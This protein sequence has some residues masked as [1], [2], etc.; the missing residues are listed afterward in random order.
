LLG[1]GQN[2]QSQWWKDTVWT[3][4]TDQMFGFYMLK[5][6]KND[7]IIVGHGYGVEL[8]D[9][10]SIFF[11]AK[12][13]EEIKR[14]KGTNEVFFINNDRNFVRLR[15]NKSKFEIFDT[16]TFFVIDSLESDAT[17]IV[18]YPPICISKD[19]RYIAA[20]VSDGFR[21]W[22]IQSKRIFKTKIY[23][24]E[25]DRVTCRMTELIFTCDNYLIGH[26]NR[27][28]QDPEH[29]GDS[30]YYKKYVYYIV[31]DLNN[32][33]SIDSFNH[34]LG[35]YISPNCKYYATVTG[36][37][38]YGADVYD[39][40]T[41]DLLWKIP[42]NSLTLTGLEFSP[43]DKYLVTSSSNSDYGLKIWKLETGKMWFEY[44]SGATY[45]NIDVSHNGK[46]I[47]FSIGRT[48]G[49]FKTHFDDVSVN[50]PFEPDR[51]LYPNPTNDYINIIVQNI[52]TIQEIGIYN[53]FGER[54]MTVETQNFVSLQK[55]DVSSLPPGVYF[56]K[57][58]NAKPMKFMVVR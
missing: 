41:K 15:E 17:K 24:Y 6:S 10:V 22:D 25:Q 44:I 9:T 39:F 57:V 20:G 51:I 31:Y 34:S 28:Y 13:G 18:D 58:G 30:K 27:T 3:K 50:E 14:I 45:S 1:S 42:V 2:A 5:F 4:E 33:D 11:D 56:L 47:A 32:L 43:D 12:T 48:I 19:A 35:I 52:E 37:G 8:A 40:N 7:S 26:I 54:V 38:T 55:I 46:F 16:K 53:I 49:V 36:D 23:P 29:P 21:I